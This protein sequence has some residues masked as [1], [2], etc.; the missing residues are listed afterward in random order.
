VRNAPG[1]AISTW[2]VDDANIVDFPLP[3]EVEGHD[4]RAQMP[5]NWLSVQ[6]PLSD[7]TTLEN[8]PTEIVPGSQYSG[9]IPPSQSDD[10]LAFRG[11]GVERIFCR[12]GDAYLFNHQ[13]WH[14]G[15]PLLAALGDAVDV[16]ARVRRIFGKFQFNPNDAST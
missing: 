14:R 9:R 7:V 2:H 3:P 5:V 6:I 11:R 13:T 10:D 15:R 1:K 8:G 12:A 4:A 16:D